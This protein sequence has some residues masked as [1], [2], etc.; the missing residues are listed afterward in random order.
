MQ[1][2]WDWT[3]SWNR[4]TTRA[5]LGGAKNKF[6]W[7][8]FARPGFDNNALLIIIPSGHTITKAKDRI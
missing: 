1:D 3:G 5:L 8:D 4:L 2:G 7:T 6:A